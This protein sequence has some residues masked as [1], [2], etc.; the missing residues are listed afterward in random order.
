VNAAKQGDFV[1]AQIVIA[2]KPDVLAVPNAALLVRDGRSFVVA[3]KAGGA[4]SAWSPVKVTTGI[5]TPEQ[6]EIVSGLEEGAEVAVRNA[7]GILSPEFKAA[8]D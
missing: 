6:T 4:D 5:V 2:K 7:I 3:R 1:F 8:G